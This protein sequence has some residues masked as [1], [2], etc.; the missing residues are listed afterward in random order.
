MEK[1]TPESNEPNPNIYRDNLAVQL[2]KIDSHKERKDVLDNIKENSDNYKNSKEN[3]SDINIIYDYLAKKKNDFPRVKIEYTKLEWPEDKGGSLVSRIDV[4]LNGVD[5]SA[6]KISFRDS[7]EDDYEYALKINGSYGNSENIWGEKSEELAKLIFNRTSGSEIPGEF[8]AGNTAKKDVANA[9][10]IVMKSYLDEENRKDD[11]DK[12]K[13]KIEAVINGHTIKVNWDEG[14]NDYCIYLPEIDPS[15]ED[16]KEKG[17]F[18]QVVRVGKNSTDAHVAFE[19]A[20][21][22]ATNTDDVDEIFL[23]VQRKF[24]SLF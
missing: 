23:A 14:Y 20:S 17:V 7:A 19:F 4:K 1:F 24:N 18:D 8:N 21:K 12:E 6:F 15:S 16:S 22:V 13:I 11:E 2:Q 3:K 10:D 5:C 9:R